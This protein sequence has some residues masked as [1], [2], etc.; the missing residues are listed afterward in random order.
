MDSRKTQDNESW[1]VD[2]FRLL[3]KRTTSDE[4]AILDIKET[5]EQLSGSQLYSLLDFWKA[6]DQIGNTSKAKERLVVA[7]EHGNYRCL[8]MP[9]G[10]TG[11]LGNFAKA[12]C[13]AFR[14]LLHIITSYFDNI[15]VHSKQLNNYL[16]WSGKK[17]QFYFKAR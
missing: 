5:I 11:A 12:I 15:T 8:T 14:E 4:V 16:S 9:F 10:H 1:M 13:L 6:F 17:V 2:D 7:T 3:N